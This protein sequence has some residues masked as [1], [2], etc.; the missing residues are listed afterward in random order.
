M[1]GQVTALVALA[2]AVLLLG[3]LVSLAL[4]RRKR[5]ASR[6]VAARKPEPRAQRGALPSAPVPAVR[7]AVKTE[8]R[9]PAVRIAV[10]EPGDRG[11]LFQYGGDGSGFE[12]DAPFAV[13][14]I[15]TTGF[16]PANGDRVVEIA[17]ARVDGT[18][19]VSDEYSTLVNPGRDVGP[20]FVHGISNSEV[21]AAPTFA[22]IAGELLDRLD[23]AV[24]VLHDGA[25]VERFLDSEF[26]RAGVQLPLVPALCS[27]WLAR[28]TLRT[29]D[30]TL[31]TLSRHAGRTV[32]DT[33]SALGAVRTVAAL[34]PQ[35][36]SVHSRP[37]HYLCGLRPMPELEIAADPSSRPVEVRESTDGWMATLLSRRRLPTAAP[38]EIDA[39]RYLD[40]VT[41]ALADGRLLGGEAQMLARLG[42]SAGLGA[43]QVDAL[44]ERLLEHL[45]AAALTDTILTTGQIRQ[46]RTAA[47]A[48]GLPT[49]FDELRPTSPQ[50]LI[51]GRSLPAAPAVPPSRSV[52]RSR[53]MPV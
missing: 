18:G 36:L 26:A 29:P 16:S 7:G 4:G 20:V 35:M 51:A 27:Q 9:R 41:E 23:G 32:L 50:D 49:Y 46:L 11:P 13:V 44:H 21:R 10:A 43:P 2:G 15:A 30:H 6:T 42:A 31:R 24:V 28:R 12:I 1:T 33:S 5:S 25:F 19:R 3:L 8:R 39:Q 37:L 14:A 45:R 38:G 48:L 17:V 52:S 53:A 47:G 34:L 22:D 40:T